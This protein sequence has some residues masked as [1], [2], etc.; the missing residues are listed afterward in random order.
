LR[1]WRWVQNGFDNWLLYAS[2][3]DYGW[4]YLGGYEFSPGEEIELVLKIFDY[5]IECT[6]YHEGGSLDFHDQFTANGLSYYC[7]NGEHVR[8][9]TTLVLNDGNYAQSRDNKRNEARVNGALY[10]GSQGIERIEGDGTVDVT[11]YDY[12]WNEDINLEINV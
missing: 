3:P 6:A 5:K 2:T 10:D 12:Y 1:I 11:T 7:N 4:H 9:M 8:I